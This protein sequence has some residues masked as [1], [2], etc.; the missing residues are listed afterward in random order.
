MKFLYKAKLN[1]GIKESNG[2][3][4]AP[5]K[6]AAIAKLRSS[7]LFVYS[8]TP[9]KETGSALSSIL[10]I[11]EGISL[12]EKVKFT[13]QMASMLNAGLPITKSLEILSTQTKNRKMGQIL[14]SILNDVESGAP[15]SKA[16][17]NQGTVFSA[18]YISLLRAGEASG[19]VDEVMRRLADTLEKQREFASRVKGAMIYP[20]IITTAMFL[21]FFL[22]VI[23]VIP[24][25]SAIYDS[26][27]IDLPVMTKALI[28]LSDFLI[29]FWWIAISIILA[30]IT[31]IRIFAATNEGEVIFSTLGLKM[32]IF[33]EIMRQSSI[34]ELTRTLGLLDEAGVPIIE[35]LAISKNSMKNR[36]FRDSIDRF[37]DDVKHGLPLSQSI[38]KERIYPQMVAQMLVVGEETG[39]VGDRLNGLAKYY[40]GEVDKVVKN[41]STAMEPLIMLMLGVM[42]GVLIISVIMPIY[43]LT[44]Q[45]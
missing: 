5:N 14:Q 32:P 18:S 6:N 30:I 37:I 22:I 24:K 26:F 1:D 38:E 4:D 29:T 35:A 19:K 16:I 7:G 25:M 43:Q 42:V 10:S 44:S 36:L 40:E 17:Q 27:N 31:G 21:V 28:A 45:F 23:F 13:D 34:V 20:G 2:T 33:G 11:F 12:S 3:I 41:L 9:I 15:L 39:T 8:L